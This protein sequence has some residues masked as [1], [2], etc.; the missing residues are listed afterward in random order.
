MSSSTQTILDA[1]TSRRL[2]SSGITPSR[3]Q[4]ATAGTISRTLPL[5]T[6][7]V[8][9]TF[10][11]EVK[12][13]FLNVGGRR[14]WIK[15]VTYGTF[16]PNEDGEP[17]PSRSQVRDDFARMRDA[18]VNTVRLYTPP[19]DWVADAATAA[20]LYLFPDICW[21]PRRC[22]F[23]QPERLKYLF[24]WTREHSRR[25]A[26]HPA[27]LLFSIGNEIPPL[28]V[29][30]YTARR[31][32]EFLRRLNDIVKEE[33]PH[34]LTTYVTH[35]PTEYL[36]LPFLDVLSYN[37]Y[38]ERQPEMRAYLA[39]MQALA[40]E[41]PVLLAEIGLD[42]RE[43]GEEAQARFLDWQIRA[44]FEKGLCGVTV[45]GWTDEWGIFGSSIEGWSFGITDPK[46]QPKKAFSVISDL[47][48]GDLYRTRKKAWPLVSVVVCC[49]N[50]AS[51][52]DQCLASL[53]QLEYPNYEVIVVDDGSKDRTFEIAAQYDVRTIR[54]PN[55]GLSKARNLGIEAAQGEVVAFIDSDAY[56]DPDW[57]YYTVSALEEHGA[58]AVGG[59]NLSPPQDGF[60]A[61][62]VDESPGNPTCVLVD[63]ERA[64][65]IPGCNMAFLKE[66]FNVVGL[67]DAQHRAAGDDVD[68][69]WRL[70][71]A[72]KK[73]VYHPSAIV[74]HHRRPTIRTYLRQQKGYGYAEAHLQKRYPGRFN[75]FGYPVWQGG[76]Y[77]SVHSHLR[78]EGLPFVFRPKIYRGFF[79]AAQFQTLYQPFLTWWFQ[80]FSTAEWLVFTACTFLSGLLAIWFGPPILGVGMVAASGL[81]VLFTIATS[82]LAGW[83][84]VQ[85]KKWKKGDRWRGLVIVGLLHVLQPLSRAVGRMKGRWQL[86]KSPLD[87]PDTD[88]LEGDLP[89]RDLWLHRLLEHM[90]SCGWVAR[91]CS[92][93][94][95]GD[96]EVL[97]PG[98]YTL[99]LTSVYE[100]DLQ[101]AL[102]YIR[103]R[104]TPKMKIHAPLVVAGLMAL[105]VGI[106]QALYLT[107]L[108]VPI[109]F[110]LTRFVGARKLMVRAVSQMAMECG[111]PIGMPKAKVYY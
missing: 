83:R 100:E 85:N 20:G 19:P 33:A 97:G 87:F 1:G 46:R 10:P 74:W 5:E 91:P 110:V 7:P 34:A 17:F 57:L 28:I 22:D 89:K 50:A 2:A 24:D 40:H 95:D 51:T 99:K 16:C 11:P 48:R 3:A 43:H 52:L 6:V 92:E 72:D 27:M 82:F 84:A 109:V 78:R 76:V 102:H 108:A 66:A 80:I 36:S 41:K 26:Q 105:L 63:N 38:L 55:G 71:V 4:A 103:Y 96:I 45:Y 53:G 101:R 56:A 30:W 13:R 98:P 59:P 77:D 60:I 104:V 8:G 31:I 32:E 12:G 90:K 49:Y 94:D 86:R 93:W 62:C 88:L 64:E 61:Q 73:I 25:L 29:R 14:F 47:Y 35:P 42:S 68:L 15:G 37:L 111:W 79:A 21:G 44:A 81:M 67:F 18:G 69:C 58:A 70:L 106:T 54:V 9:S 39:R 107:P 75:F 65:H 23:D